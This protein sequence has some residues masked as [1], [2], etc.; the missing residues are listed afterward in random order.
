VFAKEA[1]LGAT[2]APLSFVRSSQRLLADPASFLGRED[3]RLLYRTVLGA[4]DGADGIV[5]GVVSDYLGCKPAADLAIAAKLCTGAYTA[6]TCFAQPQLDFINSLHSP[7]PYGF[8]LANGI[9]QYPGLSYG[10]EVEPNGL[11]TWRT[12]AAAGL[13]YG[14]T[15]M[16]NGLFFAA[17]EVRYF[18]TQ[19][20]SADVATFDP[21]A[22]QARM[23]AVSAL[24]DATNP[25][26]TTF[27]KRNGKVLM[28]SC[29]SDEAIGPQIH[30]QYHDAVVAKMGQ[31][32]VDNFFRLYVSPS[33]SHG[34]GNTVN[35][36]GISPTGVTVDGAQTSAGTVN[37]MAVNVDWVA[38]MEAW[39]EHGQAPGNGVIATT[40]SPTA[41]FAALASKPLC[42]YPLYAKYTG[43]DPANSASYTCVASGPLSST[44]RAEEIAT[45]VVLATLITRA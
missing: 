18:W 43:T 4:C 17:N 3:I 21:T 34:C 10:G 41:P 25:D 33:A 27:N 12:G 38:V 36:A 9:T 5:D 8:S 22:Y 28:L 44:R 35:T 42:R 39:V 13:A 37:G 15:G 2:G 16:S 11:A 26:L 29:G 7:V 14:A 6:G 24:V 1:V 23:Q 32:V 45:L 20:P 19:I 31:S 40:N 30:F